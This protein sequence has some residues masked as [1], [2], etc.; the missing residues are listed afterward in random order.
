MKNTFKTIDFYGSRD[1][2]FE[3]KLIDLLGYLGNF[4]RDEA[5]FANEEANIEKYKK[6]LD[7]VTTKVHKL[8]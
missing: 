1:R 8:R 2:P 4:V 6:K 3:P 7:E 5:E